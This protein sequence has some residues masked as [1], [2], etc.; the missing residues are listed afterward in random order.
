MCQSLQKCS[1]KHA[2]SLFKLTCRH[3]IKVENICLYRSVKKSTLLLLFFS[4]LK[5]IFVIFHIIICHLKQ[6]KYIISK[7]RSCNKT[8]LIISDLILRLYTFYISIFS[9]S[10]MPTGSSVPHRYCSTDSFHRFPCAYPS[11]ESFPGLFL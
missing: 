2:I 5:I 8:N 9:F 3:F 1:I 7:I 10:F 4:H 11:Q 6:K